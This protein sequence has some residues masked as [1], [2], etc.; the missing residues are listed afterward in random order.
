[1]NL[2][3]VGYKLYYRKMLAHLRSN[4]DMGTFHN[5]IQYFIQPMYMLF[6]AICSKHHSNQLRQLLSSH[7]NICSKDADKIFFVSLIQLFKYS[8]LRMCVWTREEMWESANKVLCAL[9][10]K[11][12][13]YKPTL[14]IYI[15][16]YIY[17][18]VYTLG[19]YMCLYIF[20]QVN[21]A[22]KE[23]NL[24]K[25]DDNERRFL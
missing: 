13:D 21:L 5:C 12:P 9:K 8:V 23:V 6:A 10:N 17:A 11:I 25:V 2:F 14:Y 15:Y 18:F 3:Q 1:M 4:K 19:L 22:Q 16:I 7:W 24:I 20:Y